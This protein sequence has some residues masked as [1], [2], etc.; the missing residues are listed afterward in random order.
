M[1]VKKLLL[2]KLQINTGQIEG[3]PSN[4]RLIKD[5]RYETLKVSIKD[6]PE[7]L[8]I[9]EIVVIPHG[10]EYI[11][12]AGNMRTMAC[13]ELGWK[14][15][16]CKVLDVNTEPKK[17]RAIATKDNVNFGAW[18]WE[19]VAT[20]WDIEELGDWGVEAYSWEAKDFDGF[21][22]KKEVEDEGRGTKKLVLEYGEELYEEVL[23]RL[24]KHGKTPDAAVL[25]I[26]GLK[27]AE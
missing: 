7:M 14:H 16:P 11:V 2:S 8:A 25:S 27:I 26:L 1:I 3:L 17:L 13:K 12:V 21:F 6:D 9:R 19:L 18:D 5:D 15:V 20:E 10:K 22:E 23:E 4:P 24:G